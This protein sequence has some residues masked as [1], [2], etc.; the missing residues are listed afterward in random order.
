MEQL[1]LNGKVN[2]AWSINNVEIV[3]FG[4]GSCF[5]QYSWEIPLATYGSR[6][7][8]NTTLLLLLHP[9]GCSCAIVHLTDLVNHSSVA[10]DTFSSCGFTGIDVSGNSEVALKF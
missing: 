9:V 8:G 1:Y 6:S 10:Q 4:I 5:T 7:N 2:V 3:F